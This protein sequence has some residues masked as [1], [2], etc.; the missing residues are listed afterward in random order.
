MKDPYKN[1][2]DVIHNVSSLVHKHLAMDCIFGALGNDDRVANYFQTI[3]TYQVSN[4]WF[5][6]VADEL[7]ATHLS[8]GIGRDTC[9]KSKHIQSISAWKGSTSR[10]LLIPEALFEPRPTGNPTIWR[11][12]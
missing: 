5:R 4:P 11:L 9:L 2:S 3:T 6:R 8:S 1:V 12:L 10:I 7:E